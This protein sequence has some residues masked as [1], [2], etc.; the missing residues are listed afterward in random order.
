MVEALKLQARRVKVECEPS[1]R[2]EDSGCDFLWRGNKQW[3]GVQRKE[4]NDF[5]ASLNDG[6][7]TKEVGQ[8]KAAVQIPLVVIEG[9][10]RFINGSLASAYH[11]VGYRE[12][13]EDSWRARLLTLM[14][15]GVHVQY[16]HDRAD[17]AK[18]V[19]SA[20]QWSEKAEHSTASTRP[21][22]SGDSWGK[23]GNK[24]FQVHLLCGLPGVGPRLALRIV[25]R[26][27]GVPIELGVG[28]K[29]LMEVEG[30][31]RVKAERI[32]RVF[33]RIGQ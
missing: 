27:G 4:V 7:L 14:S 13:T 5:L 2:C 12:I 26:F 31:G 10:V 22:P 1:T 9:K 29:E 33:E 16:S 8:M 18:W 32:V 15:M 19:V 30:L 24:D 3:H 20:Y 17:T 28:V 25:E 23:V 11:R 6:R 21:G